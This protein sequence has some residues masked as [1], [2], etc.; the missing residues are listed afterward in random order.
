M[1][2]HTLHVHLYIYMCMYIY[3]HVH[4]YWKCVCFGINTESK[5]A[6][7]C[8]MLCMPFSTNAP[9]F[10]GHV[11]VNVFVQ[12]FKGIYFY[13]SIFLNILSV[14]AGVFIRESKIFGCVGRVS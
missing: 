10:H 1:Y 14:E 6:H 11:V 8:T 9:V 7:L 12:N 2:I 4:G 13:D 5:T 3:V